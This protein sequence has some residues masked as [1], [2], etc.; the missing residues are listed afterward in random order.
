M[1]GFAGGVT[2]VPA[3]AQSRRTQRV[4]RPYLRALWPSAPPDCATLPPGA[5][6]AVLAAGVLHLPQSSQAAQ[7]AEPEDVSATVAQLRLAIAAHVG[8]HLAYGGARFDRGTLAPVQC[9][10]LGA[11][12]DARVEWLAARA[13][14][15]L[16]RLWLRFHQAGPDSG[17]GFETLLARL[18]RAL[19]DPEYEDP[20]AWVRK[21]RALFFEDA[22]GE[23][24]ALHDPVAMR[25]AASLLGNDIGQMRLRFEPR[26]YR[27]EPAYRDDNSHLWLFDEKLPPSTLMLEAAASEGARSVDG[28][29]TQAPPQEHGPE[30]AAVGAETPA[31]QAVQDAV[32]APSARVARYR[33]WDRLIGR[34]RRDWVTV[35][36]SE[37][38]APATQTACAELVQELDAQAGLVRRLRS[39]L[40]AQ[41]ALRAR[42]RPARA[43]EGDGLHL[44][45]LVDAAVAQRMRVSPDPR[46][47][48]RPEAGRDPLAVT[49]LIDASTST[50]RAAHAGGKSLLAAQRLAALACADALEAEGQCCVLQAFA[51]DGRHQV[52]VRSLKEADE[53]VRAPAVIERCAA[54]QSGL[55]TRIGAALR[56]AGA[57][58]GRSPNERRLV[59][60]LSDGEPHDIDVHDPRYLLEDLRVAVGELRQRGIAVACLNLG[61]AP[62][63]GQRDALQRMF[64]AGACRNVPQPEALAQ[65]I[66]GVLAAALR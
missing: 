37:D 41:G 46:V 31:S 13:L 64:R 16:R 30:D 63:S 1:S 28:D 59:L 48:L 55:S 18:A 57:A 65:A 49:I 52:L 7:R 33:E 40:R 35:L 42:A 5:D 26:S 56:H 45:A 29:G 3:A 11:F 21:G 34:H 4:L 53:P 36:E 17:S 51:S 9:A 8:A 58:L 43:Q 20:H 23:R 15:G 50:A 32:A 6:R 25:R 22:R 66:A 47:H 38:S 61:P 44:G 39:R 54:L 14:P 10:L 19:L 2:A 12:E 27:V 62:A 24:L 60:L